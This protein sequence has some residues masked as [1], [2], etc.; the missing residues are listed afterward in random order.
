MREQWTFSSAGEVIF[1]LHAVDRVGLAARRLGVDRALIVSDKMLAEIGLVDRLRQPL[2]GAG[3]EVGLYDGCEPEPPTK[4]VYGCVE[5]V[6]TGGYDSLVA[7][8][9]GSNIDTAKA[10][11]I[12]LTHGGELPDYFGQ[13]LVPGPVLPI[14][15]VPT[16]AGTGSEVT[17]VCVITDEERNLKTAILSPYLRPRV[18]ICDPLLTLS[19]P[20][21][22]TADSGIDALTHAVESYTCVDYHYLPAVDDHNP[23]F[24]GK[25][26]LADSFALQAIGLIGQHLRAAVYQGQDVQAREKMHLASLMAGLAFSNSGVAMVHALQYSVASRVHNSH[27]EGNGLLLPY[28]MEYNLPARPVAFATIARLLGE[29]VDGLSPR[30]AAAKSV[31]AVQRLKADIGI[32]M[33]LRDVGVQEAD[34]PAMAQEAVEIQRLMLLNPRPMMLRDA[35]AVLRAA[36]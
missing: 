23:V 4:A 22:V 8:G 25:N 31:E 24:P 34:I 1:G 21:K 19:C 35:E 3:I 16:T 6:R 26:L 14:L 15:A 30:D 18:A 9:G 28:V 33:R 17:H 36:Y 2:E 11:A 13:H 5:A 10:T 29:A 32:P 20:P 7:L 12:L 27:G